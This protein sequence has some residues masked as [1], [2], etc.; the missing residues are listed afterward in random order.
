MTGH[1]VF[2]GV[3]GNMPAVPSS[4]QIRHLLHTAFLMIITIMMNL[5][6][7]KFHG[8]KMR[9]MFVLIDAVGCTDAA[10]LLSLS[11]SSSQT[12]RAKDLEEESESDL[13]NHFSST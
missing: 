6:V 12:P 3:L 11:S 13:S 4:I 10:E 1:P 7:Y 9:K 2:C 8:R 5:C